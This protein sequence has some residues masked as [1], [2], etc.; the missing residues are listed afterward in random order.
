MVSYQFNGQARTQKIL[1][2]AN[3]DTY[4]ALQE[5]NAGDQAEV[6]VTKNAAGYNQWAKIEKVSNESTDKQA[7]AVSPTGGRVLGSQYETREERQT[8]QLHIVRQSSISNAIAMLTPGAK[9]PLDVSTV[10][11]VAQDLVDFVYQNEGLEE[12]FG[13]NEE[14]STWSI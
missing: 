10:V 6:T 9:A 14:V 7:G 11:K 5:F 4:K 8:R 2:F 1:S 3:P 12:G 13:V